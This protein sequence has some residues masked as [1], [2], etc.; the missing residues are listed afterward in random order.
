M[1]CFEPSIYNIYRDLSDQLFTKIF[2]SSVVLT[3]FDGFNGTLWD[4]LHEIS[5]LSIGTVSYISFDALETLTYQYTS[6]MLESVKDYL[7]T[8]GDREK[9]MDLFAMAIELHTLIQH[10]DVYISGLNADTTYINE[11]AYAL[12]QSTLD[13]TH[14]A[15]LESLLVRFLMCHSNM[16]E[17]FRK[18][19][20]W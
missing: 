8:P 19:Y 17:I 11:L 15:L 14:L 5:V 1:R 10:L 9:Y 2:Q 12:A 18:I 6:A 20:H 13:A 16:N 7:N 4:K 3:K